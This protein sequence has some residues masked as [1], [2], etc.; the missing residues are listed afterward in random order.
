MKFPAPWSNSR[1]GFALVLTLIML[2][3]AAVTVV[4]FLTT[5]TTERTNA[6]AYGKTNKAELFSEA[7]VNAAIARLT[8]EM[9][10]R[11]Y[12]AIGYRSVNTGLGTEVIPVITG[13]RSTNP[14][15]PTYNTAPGSDVYLV[16]TVDP[17]G[18]SPPGSIAPT[19]LTATNS[20]DLNDNHVSTEPHGWIGSPTSSAGILPYRVAW[21]VVFTRPF[22]T[23][24]ARSEQCELQSGD[25]Q[26]R[27]LDR[28]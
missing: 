26:I 11:P 17:A 19:A 2:V 27:I 20:V 10:Y 12:H 28:R 3:L 13:P 6:A 25:R 8:T 7:A 18:T 24:A 4:A 16:S 23:G 5:I 1:S 21:I 14:N 22:A 15:T 9:Q